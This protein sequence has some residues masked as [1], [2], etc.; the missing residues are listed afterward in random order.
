MSAKIRCSNCEKSVSHRERGGRIINAKNCRATGEKITGKKYFET[1]KC[2]EFLPKTEFVE[3]F[4][5]P[6]D[7]AMEMIEKGKKIKDIIDPL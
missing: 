7:K 6:L 5:N 3:Q 2:P 4:V 1:R